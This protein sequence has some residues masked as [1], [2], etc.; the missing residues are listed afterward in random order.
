M[1]YVKINRAD[2]PRLPAL[3]SNSHIQGKIMLRTKFKLLL[4]S[5]LLTAAPLALAFQE[6]DWVLGKYREGRY[7]FP[8]VVTS[9][10]SGSVNLQ[11]D[12]GEVE[13]LPTSAV[14]D[15][16]WKV[17]TRVECNFQGKGEWYSGKLTKLV[18]E[19]FA[20]SI[21]YDDGDRE[22]TRTGKCRSQ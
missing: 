5:L 2:E 10:S 22:D 11:Y 1:S 16:N 4:G 17:G 6:G 14:K 19:E 12:D 13:T 21:A 18:N 20:L 15:Y 7:Y 9:A 8:G 3:E